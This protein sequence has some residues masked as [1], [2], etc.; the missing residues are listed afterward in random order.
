MDETVKNARWHTEFRV[1]TKEMYFRKSR[2]RAS[3]EVGPLK[4]KFEQTMSY[5]DVASAIGY[6]SANQKTFMFHA[7]S[8]EVT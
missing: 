5:E 6:V 1:P 3:G 4:N 7:S 2:K 8:S